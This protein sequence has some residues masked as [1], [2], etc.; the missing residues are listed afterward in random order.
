MLGRL[1]ADPDL[2]A[3]L[4]RAGRLWCL[5]ERNWRAL[6]D[7]IRGAHTEA[8]ARRTTSS[9]T[10]P[11]H[12]RLASLRV[13]LIADE[14]TSQTLSASVQTVPLDRDGWRDQLDGLDLVFI[15]SAW[16]GNGGQW[17]RG[18]GYY[19]DE[20]HRRPRRP[21]RRDPRARHPDG[22]LEQ[23]GPRPLRALRAHGGTVRP[24]L[25]DRRQH[26]RAATS[27]RGWA[28]CARR[29]RCR[30]TPSP[31]STTRCRA[32][33]RSSRRVAYAGTYYGERYA[34]RSAELSRLLEAARPFGLAIYDR[35]LAVPDSP[36]HFPPAFRRDV[37]GSLP[38][39]EVIDS[40]KAHVANLNVNSVADSP[41]MFS[42]RV[43]EVAAC[44]GVVLSGPGRGI[45]ETFG[46]AI[47]STGDTATWRALLR[48]WSIDPQARLREAWLQMRA[49]LRAHTVD[50]ALT[51]LARTAGIPVR[52]SGLP[53]YAVVLDGTRADLLDVVASQSVLPTA[54]LGHGRSGRG[55]RGARRR[56]R[57]RGRVARLVD[58]RDDGR[59][60]RRRGRRSWGT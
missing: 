47:P 56:G 53:T 14:F 36:Y 32:A 12:A 19:S 3:D 2:R 21:A 35:Q 1:I 44:G 52:A 40:Y 25:H 13:G 57:A 9:W 24:R 29:R 51:I 46:S 43:V 54:R 60:H 11:M 45:E 27:R 58:R 7:A 22:L 38:Y 55:S 33:A 37:R 6:G 49:V 8:R 20:E 30:S 34:K 26:G 23:G 18:V 4:G 39:D 16:S 42:R 5:D 41:S 10:T 28:R 48:D 15:E 50:T 17:H 31:A 59:A